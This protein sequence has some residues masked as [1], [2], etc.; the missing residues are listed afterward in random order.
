MRVKYR[1]QVGDQ[2]CEVDTDFSLFSIVRDLVNGRSKLQKGAVRPEDI[3]ITVR[4]ADPEPEPE[5][6]RKVEAE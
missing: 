2:A 6:W 4:E 5:Q 1:I 3:R